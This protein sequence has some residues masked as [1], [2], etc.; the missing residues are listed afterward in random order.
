VY[1]LIILVQMH[2]TNY[3]QFILYHIF[4]GINVHRV[5]AISLI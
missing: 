2:K 4:C 3:I 1:V 5:H